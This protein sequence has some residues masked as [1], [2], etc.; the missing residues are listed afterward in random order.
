MTKEEKQAYKYDDE[1]GYQLDILE[2]QDSEAV[3]NTYYRYPKITP[4]INK[5]ESYVEIKTITD[6]IQIRKIE[7]VILYI[8]TLFK[9]APIWLIQQWY[10]DYNDDGYK[11]IEDWVKVGIVWANATSMGVFLQPTK[12]LLDLY[13]TKDQSYRGIPFGLLN[14][15][16]A[17]EQM[18]F[19]IMMGNPKSE[20]WRFVAS[21]RLNLI[22]AYHP[23]HIKVPNDSGT[24]VIPES[25]FSI[26]RYDIKELPSRHDKLKKEILDPSK[27]FTS[28]FSDFTLFPIVT[29]NSKG[30]IITQKPDVIIP[31][32]RMQGKP[33]SCSIELELSC[34]T[35]D[36]YEQIMNNYKN[37]IT[38]GKLFYLC[39]NSRISEMVTTAYKKVRGLGTCKL[40]IIPYA[41]PAQRLTTFTR[42]YEDNQKT[43]LKLS[44]DN[45]KKGSDEN[46]GREQHDDS[47]NTN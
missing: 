42:E 23:L 3:K 43:I 20:L 9:F 13:E 36:K 12:F 38:F 7:E 45:T 24:I 17:E 35:A 27:H 30:N 4:H 47:N 19:D 8:I 2:V 21:L 14:H 28:E 44:L 25:E 32:P 1:L 39:G 29:Y 31:I 34:K 26:N 11:K 10:S 37:N 6:S 33:Q 46:V 40:Y 15:T 22:H 41:A 18:I 16:C 5:F